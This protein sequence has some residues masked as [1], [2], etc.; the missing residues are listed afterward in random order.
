MST[1]GLYG[2]HADHGGHF[3]F[4]PGQLLIMH[5]RPRQT[6]QAGLQGEGQ[7][8][9]LNVLQVDRKRY[10][11]CPDR[12]LAWLQLVLYRNVGQLLLIATAAAVWRRER[13]G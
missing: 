9:T 8:S 11:L 7:V 4:S 1:W 12:A 6:L 13:E 2:G 10:K 5:K 3:M